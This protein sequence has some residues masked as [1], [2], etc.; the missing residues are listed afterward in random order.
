LK[1]ISHLLLLLLPASALAQKEAPKHTCRILFF[2]APPSAPEELYLYDG[3]TSIKVEL[4]R[5]NFSPV[6]ELPSGN[7]TL[8]LLPEPPADPEKLPAG[9]PFVRVPESVAD[10]YLLVT[11]DPANTVAPVR[12][13]V[14]EAGGDK[15]KPG[16]MMWFNLTPNTVGGIVGVQKLAIRPNARLILDPPADGNEDYPVDLSF[17]MPGDEHLYP[18]CQTRWRHDPRSRSVIFIHADPD[19]RAPRVM[20]YSDFRPAK[21][22]R[23]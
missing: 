3:S 21:P 23:P 13:Q 20:G 22:D 7:L 8:M 11:S 5:M 9:A 12:M 15:L 6:Y 18:L 10:F 17:Q 1:L 4:P 16:Q 14:I 19:R 2:D